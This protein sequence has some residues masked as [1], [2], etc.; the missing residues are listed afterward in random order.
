MVITTLEQNPLLSVFLSPLKRVQVRG[1]AQRSFPL[2]VINGQVPVFS[3]VMVSSGAAIA[4]KIIIDALLAPKYSCSRLV[5]TLTLSCDLGISNDLGLDV[6]LSA[7]PFANI[8]TANALRRSSYE[9]TAV[10]AA[11]IAATSTIIRSGGGTLI[12]FD[13]TLNVTPAVNTLVANTSWIALSAAAPPNVALDVINSATVSIDA[14][15]LFSPS[16]SVAACTDEEGSVYLYGNWT[17]TGPISSPRVFQIDTNPTLESAISSGA[18]NAGG[19]LYTDLS[20]PVPTRRGSG[21]ITALRLQG[22]LK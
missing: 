19:V 2:P 15:V 18:S 17:N 3:L 14:N 4:A 6:D 16:Y 11:T 9:D 5:E 7:I 12:Q 21:A 8:V 13:Q 1:T 22:K 20:P 10:T